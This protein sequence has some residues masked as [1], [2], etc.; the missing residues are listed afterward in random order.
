M[1]KH[2]VGGGIQ[3]I[4]E[5]VQLPV[6]AQPA[7][8]V[9]INGGFT[10]NILMKN[11]AAWLL[12]LCVAAAGCGGGSKR[13]K[14]Y[15]VKGKI[16]VKG[17]PIAGAQVAFQP[18]DPKSEARGATGITKDDG[19]FVLGT[20]QTGDGAVEGE[21]KVIVSKTEAKAVASSGPITPG[22]PPGAAGPAGASGSGGDYSKMMI[23]KGR[24]NPETAAKSTGEI[25]A[26]YSDPNQTDLRAKIGPDSPNEFTFNIE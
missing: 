23:S 5:F 2:R 17:Q 26:K 18:V 12:L 24:D 6:P 11:G 8:A 21:Y 7:R 19:S 13:P 4:S 14:L 15:S 20:F 16:T 9:A 3:V 10:M 25:P 1:C 22:G